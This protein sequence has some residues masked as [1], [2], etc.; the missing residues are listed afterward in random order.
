MKKIAIFGSTGSIGTNALRVA[1]HLVEEIRPVVLAAHSN[2]DLLAQQI[3]HYE[4]E[5]VAVY[6]EKKGD[7]L[8]KQFPGVEV[9]Y[10]E[11]GLRKAA[12]HPSVEFVLMAIVGMQA[13]VPTV[14]ALKAGKQLALANKEVLVSAGQYIRELAA[15]KGITLIPIDSEHSALFQCLEGRKLTDVRRLILTA[16]GGPFRETALEKLKQITVE[17][18]LSHP[19][20]RMGPKVTIDSSTL[21]NKGLEMIEA[22]WLFN[23]PPEKIEVVI[24]PQSIIH[25]LVE[26]VDG[27]LL[28][29]LSEPH[30]IYPIQYALTYPE[31]RPGLFPP[32]DFVKNSRLDFLPP[33]TSKFRSLTLVRE[34][35]Q[36][37]E[38]ACCYLNAAN[39]ILVE[40]FM[41][42]QISWLDISY[43][44]EQLMERHHKQPLQTL[45]SIYQVDQQARQ[46]AQ[47]I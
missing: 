42:K 25:S 40:R 28:A 33:D 17:Q 46:E 3:R 41:K 5:L 18:A 16:S 23:I 43:K 11:E 47:S 20:W 13:L 9:V 4:P 22:R 8:Q 44:L 35:L 19:T 36:E 7:L 1:S 30:M 29:Q 15:S 14:E 45:E 31:R 32:F 12:S 6:D 37:G 21:M 39:E 24:H 2:I 10:G 34:A 26:F 27:S 38:S